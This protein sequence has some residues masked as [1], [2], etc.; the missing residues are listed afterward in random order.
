MC[1][2]KTM[3]QVHITGSTWYKVL[4]HHTMYVMGIY[5]GIQC[6]YLWF[7]AS[8]FVVHIIL[9]THQLLCCSYHI[10]YALVTLFVQCV[11]SPIKYINISQSNSTIEC[12]PNTSVVYVIYYCEGNSFET[13][14]YL[15]VLHN[16]TIHHVWF[17]CT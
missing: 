16:I 6:G 8:S 1:L 5:L 3:Y 15:R 2:Y 9:R 17:M 10:V 14:Q 12:T 4:S 13:L 7:H 11:F